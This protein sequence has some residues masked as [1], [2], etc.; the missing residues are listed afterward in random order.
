MEWGGANSADS[1]DCVSKTALVDVYKRLLQ[2][3]SA[4]GLFLALT[5]DGSQH[6]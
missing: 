3:V 2:A 4:E 5:Y 6:P 1:G